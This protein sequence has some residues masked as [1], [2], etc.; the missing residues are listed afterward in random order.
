YGSSSDYYIGRG[1]TYI[2]SK[3]VWSYFR[4]HS[5]FK[6][7]YD[8]FLGYGNMVD[9]VIVYFNDLEACGASISAHVCSAVLEDGLPA[10]DVY[11]KYIAGGRSCGDI[12]SMIYQTNYGNQ[13]A[14]ILYADDQK[15]SS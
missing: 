10:G 6:R 1:N 5:F 12:F 2:A 3:R 14:H 11:H 15:F 8:L 4:N 7:V 13:F 9:S